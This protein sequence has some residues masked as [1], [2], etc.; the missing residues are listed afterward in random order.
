M[1]KVRILLLCSVLL[2]TGCNIVRLDISN[3]ENTVETIIHT[4]S[5]LYNVHFDGY[6]YYLPRNFR[7]I[8]RDGFNMLLLDRYNNRFFMYV[9]VV[10]YYHE[11]IKEFEEN[12]DAYF[13]RG[14]R[15]EYGFGYLEIN[16]VDGKYFIEAMFNYTK[17]EVFVQREHLSESVAGI[18]TILN[19][20]RFNRIILESIIGDNVLD[21]S[22]ETFDIFE[23]RRRGSSVEDFLRYIEEFD[24]FYD[25]NNQLPDEDSIILD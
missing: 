6:R 22:E 18:F 8:N 14:F 24:R 11:I 10:S 25:Q 23:T 17:I 21:Y 5:S 9:D 2:L 13:S 16:E 1:K 15:T 7:L 19:S 20:V 12:E 3:I 4:N